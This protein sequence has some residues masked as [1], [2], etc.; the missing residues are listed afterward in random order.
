MFGDFRIFGSSHLAVLGLLFLFSLAI[1]F[2]LSKCPSR[3]Q[4]YLK[5]A[6]IGGLILQLLAFNSW[7][8]LHQT[9]DITRFLPFHLCTISVYLIIYTLRFNN[10]FVNKLVLFWSPISAFVA[11]TLPDM[12]A[13]ENFP[14]FRFVE[15]FGSHLLIIWSCVYIL[16]VVKP[17]IEFKDCLISFACL[18]SV[19]PLV[20]GI[21]YIFKSNYMYL[22]SRPAGGQTNFLTNEPWHVLGLIVIFGIVFFV[23]YLFYKTQ[24][25]NHN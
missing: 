1:W 13:N 21:N 7:H 3:F 6:L 11:I 20:W 25:T 2:W 8:F 19:L 18:I 14:S 24:N 12:S 4:K 10:N 23:E 9:F 5:F 22:M 16:G 15:F 17:K